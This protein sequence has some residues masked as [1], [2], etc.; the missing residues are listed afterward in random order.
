ML[1]ANNDEDL[2]LRHAAVLALARIGEVAPIVALADSD[3]RSLRI[4]AVLVLRRLQHEQVALFLED[5]DEYIVTEAARAIN[6]DWSIEPAL[7]ALASLL[8]EEKYTSE[9]LLRRSINAALRVGGE[10]E[11]DLLVNFARRPTVS[12]VLRGEALAAIGTWASPSVLDRVDGRYRGEIQRDAN[13][14]REK[15]EDYIPD[16][17]KDNDPDILVAAARAL[18]TLEINGYNDQL[19]QLMKSHGSAAVRSA[20]LTALG[21]L[22]YSKIEEAMKIGMADKNQDVRTVA[23]GLVTQLDI[24]KE[25]LPAIVEPIFKNG[26]IVEQQK[27]LGVLGEMPLEKSKDVLS[28]LI[29]QGINKKLSNGVIL[30]LAEAVEATKSEELIAQLDRLKPKGDGLEAYTETLYGGNVRAGYQYFNNNPAGQCVRCHAVRGAGGV[31]GP[32]LDNIGNTLT[33]EQLL[34][35]LI[36]PSARLA[37]G[38]GMVT[39]TLKDGQTI[40][41]ILDE[42]TEEELILKTS[43]AEPMEIALSRIEKRQNMASSMPPMGTVMSKREIRDVIE[44]L[45]VLKKE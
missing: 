19:A 35:A 22:K 3:N 9:P 38:Y 24:P 28:S 4:A 41:G 15:I 43:D 7:P 23:V 16:F 10:K 12:S 27:M 29:K 36:N 34:E 30:D 20:M 2:Y 26:S 25:K 13:L 44:F 39:V 17:L 1:E 14:V 6:D 33:R 11:L 31:V 8:K 37:P 18:S 21:D 5:K 32:A 40:T 42:E 45:S